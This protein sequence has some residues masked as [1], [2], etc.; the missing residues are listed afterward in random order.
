MPRAMSSLLQERASV[1]LSRVSRKVLGRLPRVS[2]ALCRGSACL[3]M[4][5]SWGQLCKGYVEERNG[6]DWLD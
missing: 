3:L 2:A 1:T 6:Y 5:N 4:L